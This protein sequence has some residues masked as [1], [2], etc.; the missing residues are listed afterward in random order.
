[1]PPGRN[2]EALEEERMALQLDPLSS[3][4][5]TNMGDILTSANQLDQAIQQY[6][7]VI[8]MD[9]HFRRGAFQFGGIRMQDSDV[10]REAIRGDP[11]S[12]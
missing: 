11:N 3:I 10:F 2:K 6:L 7:M 1:M 4:I 8:R 9:P 12:A 5:N